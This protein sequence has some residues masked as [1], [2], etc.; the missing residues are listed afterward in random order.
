M[1]RNIRQII[2][3]LCS[4]MIV[5]ACSHDHDHKHDEEHGYHEEGHA[6]EIRLSESVLKKLDLQW[7]IVKQGP[8]H[9]EVRVTGK[10][11][12]DTDKVDYLFTP[13]SGTVKK[14]FVAVGDR[15]KKAAPL[16]QING[17]PLNA[18]REGTVLAINTTVG[19]RVGTMQSLVVLADIETMRV[20]FDVYPQDMDIVRIGQ[21]VEVTLI[22]HVKEVFSGTVRYLSPNLDEHSQTL[23]VAADVDNTDHHLKFGMFV[24]GKILS[25]LD[26]Q[27]LAI[28]EAA[29]V[30]YDQDFAVFV[31]GDE[32][33][34]FIKK[35]IKI[36]RRGGGQVEV[37]SGLEAGDKVVINGS[38]TLKS[39][40]LKEHIGEGHGH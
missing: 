5:G 21:Q 9:K 23:K 33:G 18:P 10:A 38:F 32:D 39:E 29:V 8:L 1:K 4:L 37:L 11:V 28:P 7:A 24:K 25:T 27:A 6:E 3:T 20:V 34:T 35:D 40:S 31:P 15:V 14:I 13:H 30:R 19:S 12:Q 16:L 17:R 36:G 22:G 26:E 2:V